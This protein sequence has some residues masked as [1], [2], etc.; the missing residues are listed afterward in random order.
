MLNGRST[1]LRYDGHM[2]EPLKLNNGIRQGNPLS[3]VLY[4]FYNADLLDTPRDKS[5]DALA[6][7]DNTIM[8]AAVEN[9]T[10]VH[11][12]LADMMYR[13]GGV[14]E[15]SKTHNSPLEYTKLALIDFAYRS[16]RKTRTNLQLPQR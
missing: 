3:M 7:V 1:T 8:V 12:K 9:F 16:S 15:W 6:Y 14:T 11:K 5:E 10:Q 13:E 4:Q 2:S